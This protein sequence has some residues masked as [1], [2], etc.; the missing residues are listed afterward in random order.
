MQDKQKDVLDFIK[1]LTDMGFNSTGGL[2][3]ISNMMPKN[4]RPIMDS[5]M[6]AMAINNGLT[7]AIVN[8]CD[9]RLMES[10]KSADIIMNNTLYADSYLEI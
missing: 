8:P 5:V 10:I 1:Q 4:I 3:N 2:S 6:V 7:S 9:V